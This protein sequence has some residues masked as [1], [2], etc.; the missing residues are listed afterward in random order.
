VGLLSGAKGA[1]G[2]DSE[3]DRDAAMSA[4][5]DAAAGYSRISLPELERL[6]LQNPQWLRDLEASTIDG[7]RA[8][9]NG[10]G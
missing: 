7:D 10:G 3:S 9:R 1:L 5:Q 6:I 8:C 4:L 2:Y